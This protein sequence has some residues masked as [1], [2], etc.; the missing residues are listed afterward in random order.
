MKV[1][2]SGA[3]D[4]AV[5]VDNEGGWLRE[6]YACYDEQWTAVLTDP[7][8]GIGLVVSG[9]YVR[10][11]VWRF[12]VNQVNEEMA[13]PSWPITIDQAPDAPYSVRLTVDAPEAA[14]LIDIDP[15]PGGGDD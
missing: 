11:G 10:D 2:F 14:K 15:I 8:T 3:S 4:D 13:L 1:W 12:G 6:E 9:E 5:E 7:D